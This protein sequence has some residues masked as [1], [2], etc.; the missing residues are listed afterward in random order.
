MTRGSCEYG[1][2]VG[3]QKVPFLDESATCIFYL[4]EKVLT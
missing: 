4:R 1:R 3:F 2:Q